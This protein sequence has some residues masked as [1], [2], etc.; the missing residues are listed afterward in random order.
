MWGCT[1]TGDVAS[2][3]EWFPVFWLISVLPVWAGDLAWNKITSA[4]GDHCTRM[5]KICICRGWIHVMH[6]TNTSQRWLLPL[7]GGFI[8]YIYNNDG[9]WLYVTLTNPVFIIMQGG[10]WI[11]SPNRAYMS[12]SHE[13][14]IIDFTAV[15]QLFCSMQ[16]VLPYKE[17]IIHSV[18]CKI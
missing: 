6:I 2:V 10:W 11:W 15:R 7:E 1:N 5:P 12:K 3:A 18:F 17:I 13:Y 16:N 8:V 4:H 9:V 14:T